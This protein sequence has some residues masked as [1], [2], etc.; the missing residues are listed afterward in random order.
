MKQKITWWAAE[1]SVL[2]TPDSELQSW[3]VTVRQGSFEQNSANMLKFGYVFICEQEVEFF[4]PKLQDRI[5]SIQEAFQ[6]EI[7]RVR[8][9]AQSRVSEI[10]GRLQN[11]LALSYDS[12][13]GDSNVL[14]A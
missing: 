4:M 2:V 12:R 14:D 13:A 10:E 11:L 6:S 1:P 3:H 8:A 9:E 7:Q 5:E